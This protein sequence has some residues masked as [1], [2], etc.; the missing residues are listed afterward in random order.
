MTEP[1]SSRIYGLALTNHW[2][3]MLLAAPALL[4][5]PAGSW[6]VFLNDLKSP[7]FWIIAT[8]LFLLGLTPYLSILTK[9]DPTIA[10]LGEI[11]SLEQLAGYI[12]RSAYSDHHVIADGGD[13]LQYMLWLAGESGRQRCGH[14]W[15]RT[16]GPYLHR[17]CPST[18]VRNAVLIS[19]TH[20]TRRL[21]SPETR[22]WG[23]FWIT[24]L[25]STSEV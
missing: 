1:A 18:P 9:T 6:P 23:R 7:Q 12:A 3:L 2:P 22:P 20:R 5:V 8:G 19:S 25:I 14:S 16:I 10:L 4:L 15:K 11:N 17:V 21:P 24:C 13:R